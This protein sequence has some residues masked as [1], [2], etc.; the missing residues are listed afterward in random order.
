MKRQA[1]ASRLS[2]WSLVVLIA[3]GLD[4]I[5][6]AQQAASAPLAPNA[7][8]SDTQPETRESSSA[9]PNPAYPDAP[10]AQNAPQSQPEPS[11][12]DQSKPPLGT[13]AAPY[14]RPTGVTGSKPAGAAI[15]PAKQKRTRAILISVGLIAAGAVAIGAVAGMSRSSPSHPIGAN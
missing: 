2:A 3:L 12:G 7:V 6:Q 1:W 13:A 15:A 9:Q 14:T 10:E 8:Q 5:A 11:S 4:G